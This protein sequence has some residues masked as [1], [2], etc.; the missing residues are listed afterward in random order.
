MGLNQSKSI[1]VND[2]DM[3]KKISNKHDV[4][5]LVNGYIRDQNKYFKLDSGH[6]NEIVAF[7]CM[8]YP[9]LRLFQDYPH[10]KFKVSEDGT[11]ITSIGP[12]MNG[13]HFYMIYPTPNGFNKGI[14]EWRVKCLKARAD[15]SSGYGYPSSIGVMD[16]T[17]KGTYYGGEWPTDNK[18]SSSYWYG[19]WKENETIEIILNLDLLIVEYYTINNDNDKDTKKIKLKQDTL[20]QNKIYHFALRVFAD[21]SVGGVWQSVI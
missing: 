9:L 21:V 6:L 19:N 17:A 1:T 3:N 7:I 13:L 4:L 5:N 18:H 8:F 2:N 10:D 16:Q 20:S 15:S 11:I 12:I 14:H